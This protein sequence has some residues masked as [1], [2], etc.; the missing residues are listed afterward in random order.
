MQKTITKKISNNS[1][2]KAGAFYLTVKKKNLGKKPQTHDTKKHP[3]TPQ[4]N[5]TKKKIKTI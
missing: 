2:R 5:K 4:K 1:C 3:K